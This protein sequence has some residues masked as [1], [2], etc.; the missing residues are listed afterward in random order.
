MKKG[1]G[2]PKMVKTGKAGRPRKEWNMIPV[3]PLEIIK[4][5][6][7]NLA[8]AP[9]PAT[10]EEALSGPYA[11]DWSAAVLDEFLAHM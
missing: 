7:A 5:E 10:L 1:P 4:E 3:K 8:E 11:D 2:R 6:M 9:D